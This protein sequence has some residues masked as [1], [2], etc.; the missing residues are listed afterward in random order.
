MNKDQDK[1]AQEL[2]KTISEW[3][4]IRKRLAELLMKP[5]PCRSCV[6]ADVRSGKILCSRNCTEMR[7]F[8][9]K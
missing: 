7:C 5:S 8:S 2:M 9:H 1:R 4:Q 3:E 6:W